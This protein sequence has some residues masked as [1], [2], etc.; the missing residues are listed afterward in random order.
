MHLEDMKKDCSRTV[1]DSLMLKLKQNPERRLVRVQSAA[2]YLSVSKRVLRRFIQDGQI[3]IVQYGE[4]AAWLLDLN[5][6]DRWIEQH[7]VTL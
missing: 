6:L 3:P 5:D 4:N 7:K 1:T 2:D